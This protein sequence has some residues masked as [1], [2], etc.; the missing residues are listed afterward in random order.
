MDSVMSPLPHTSRVVLFAVVGQS[1]CEKEGLMYGSIPNSKNRFWRSIAIFSLN[2]L[3]LKAVTDWSFFSWIYLFSH[4]IVLHRH[5]QHKVNSIYTRPLI[6]KKREG[7]LPSFLIPRTNT[8]PRILDHT[9]HEDALPH[10]DVYG[11]VFPP[12]SPH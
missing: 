8:F 7:V 9:F 5:L 2:S 3:F 4:G 10:K 12:S 6:L 1:Y 11:G